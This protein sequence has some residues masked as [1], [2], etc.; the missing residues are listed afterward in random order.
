M[1]AMSNTNDSKERRNTNLDEISG[2][3]LA[4]SESQ[5]QN[6]TFALKR[7]R[8]MG[9]FDL[10]GSSEKMASSAAV[11]SLQ[12]PLQFLGQDNRG[13]QLGTP[14]QE[15]DEFVEHA[16]NVTYTEHAEHAE[17]VPHSE[18]SDYA[19]YH[20]T[21]RNQAY[22]KPELAPS[23]S[24]ISLRTG[25]TTEELGSDRSSNGSN[26]S[27]PGTP[28]LLAPALDDSV[29]QYEPSRHVDYLSHNWKESD[30]SSS[31]RYIVLRRKD[32]A[33]SARLENA[34]WRTWTKAKYNLKTVSPESVNW[35][36]DY[37]VTWLYGP[38][39]DE[40][41][42]SY[43]VE[44][45]G[46]KPTSNDH[47]ALSTSTTTSTSVSGTVTPTKASTNNLAQPRNKHTDNSR[48]ED[49]QSNKNNNQNNNNEN[50]AAAA[51]CK[52]ILKK[53][54]ATQV[55]LSRL[56][57][58][59]GGEWDSYTSNYLRHHN[60]RHRDLDQSKDNVSYY[61]NQQYMRSPQI[62]RVVATD[63]D[64][65]A[66]STRS[67]ASSVASSVR[68]PSPSLLGGK[69]LVTPPLPERRIHFN[70]RVEQCIA[71]DISESES[72][73]ESDTEDDDD[74]IR[75]RRSRSQITDSTSAMYQS[76]SYSE[77]DSCSGSESESDDQGSFRGRGRGRGRA[78]GR[79]SDRGRARGR[80]GNS[81]MSL[82]VSDDDDEDSDTD[83]DECDA[84]LFLNMRSN[85]NVSLVAK[86]RD[87]YRTISLLP[88]TTLKYF[89]DEDERQA[90]EVETA[91][92]VAHA[93]SH[94]SVS[95]RKGYGKYDYSSV[96][97]SPD[98]SPIHSPRESI[99]SA[100]PVSQTTETVVS[101][102]IVSVSRQASS[103]ML[104]RMEESISGMNAQPNSRD[105][106]G[107]LSPTSIMSL[108]QQLGYQ[109]PQSQSPLQ[110]QSP[111]QSPK[112]ASQSTSSNS[113]GS[114]AVR[115]HDSSSSL[116]NLA[117][118]LWSWKK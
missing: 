10:G 20:E 89:L 9:L 100:T 70:S 32:M 99:G 8:S 4:S 29:I 118:S 48:Q 22:D 108:Q 58:G 98:P 66:L 65:F 21:A 61:V 115:S 116:R 76:A 90:D 14:E 11:P 78:R 75:N 60:Y 19:S 37:D 1:Q 35:L 62:D 3:V 45:E 12:P 96:Y 112:G 87:K 16:E 64:Y 113:N 41:H 7:T 59:A 111:S 102:Q 67:K 57:S 68:S 92:R 27:L 39:Y 56:P 40:P 34:S 84:G 23:L 50:I 88:A 101:G 36:K 95:F 18:H 69:N 53:R 54:S 17:D 104:N 63:D 31:W 109:S 80:S 77:S 24:G 107:P 91:N 15:R 49:S 5:F 26:S 71:V 55:I 72:Q 13:M 93:M 43:S 110:S 44:T 94:N 106:S 114:Q 86:S 81:V 74:T 83:D 85:S 103:S 105:D 6:S 42:H 33:N 30:I 38:L 73:D 117:T 51:P 79:T 2:A 97:V 46:T 28:E 82:G 47:I 25:S 52:P